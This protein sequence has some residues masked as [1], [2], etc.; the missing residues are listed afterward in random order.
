MDG[1]N[2]QQQEKILEQLQPV[3]NQNRETIAVGSINADSS[4]FITKSVSSK[5]TYNEGLKIILA[6]KLFPKYQFGL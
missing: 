6:T 4:K 2:L 5:C 3:R 1:A